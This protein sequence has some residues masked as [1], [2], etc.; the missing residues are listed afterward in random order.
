VHSKNHVPLPIPQSD[1]FGIIIDGDMS[2]DWRQIHRF[3]GQPDIAIGDAI[4][5]MERD[6][7]GNWRE[8]AAP[9][10]VVELLETKADGSRVF[11]VRLGRSVVIKP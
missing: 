7:I 8:I 11:S 9:V 5:G 4:P 3:P 6:K 10:E 1:V 2:D